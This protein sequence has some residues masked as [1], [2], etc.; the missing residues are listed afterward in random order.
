MAV[1]N[2]YKSRKIIE[3]VYYA[4]SMTTDEVKRSLINHDGYDANIT[5]RKQYFK[6]KID[7]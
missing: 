1:F 7:K 4:K 6:V 2:V 5:V 3:T